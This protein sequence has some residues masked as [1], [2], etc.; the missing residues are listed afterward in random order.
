MQ[1]QTSVFQQMSFGQHII[2]AI[3]KFVSLRHFAVLNRTVLVVLWHCLFRSVFPDGTQKY[4][5]TQNVNTDSNVH[6]IVTSMELLEA[7]VL[8][9]SYVAAVE[10]QTA[11]E[12]RASV[13][14]TSASPPQS[15]L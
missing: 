10:G 13:E 12:A 15:P 6:N 9:G 4:R 1:T 3:G 14:P 5:N 8:S 7:I 2:S 11:M